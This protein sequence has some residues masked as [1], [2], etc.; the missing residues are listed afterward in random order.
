MT[1]P[2]SPISAW[3]TFVNDQVVDADDMNN[4][5]TLIKTVQT[6]A[7][8]ED[9]AA[10]QSPPTTMCYLNGSQTIVAPGSGVDGTAVSFTTS[11]NQSRVSWDI[12]IDP[13]RVTCIVPGTYLVVGGAHY[14]AASTAVGVRGARLTLNSTAATAALRGCAQDQT[15]LTAGLGNVFGFATVQR[16]VVN[17]SLRLMVWHNDS[18]ARPVDNTY[19]GTFLGLA[20]LGL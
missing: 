14:P 4:L 13:T 6:R 8:G 7:I 16:L 20:W 11:T 10:R 5:I 15:A 9:P 17:D 3:P 12:T 19:G 2:A 1:A 18:T